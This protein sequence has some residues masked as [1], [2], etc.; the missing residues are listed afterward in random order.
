MLYSIPAQLI[1]TKNHME[2]VSG[3]WTF[4]G[5]YIYE[6]Q[7]KNGSKHGFIR[8]TDNDGSIYH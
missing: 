4:D 5:G 2:L 1:K 3:I 6:G 7:W 8:Y